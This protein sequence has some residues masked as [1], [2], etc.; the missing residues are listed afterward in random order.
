MHILYVWST[1]SSI[2][3]S[4]HTQSKVTSKMFP[5]SYGHHNGFKKGPHHLRQLF[6]TLKCT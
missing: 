5:L 2:W 6:T 1:F 3:F 4:F